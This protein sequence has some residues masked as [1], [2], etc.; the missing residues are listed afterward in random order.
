[1][2]SENSV[3][4]LSKNPGPCGVCIDGVQHTIVFEDRDGIGRALVTVEQAAHLLGGIGKPYFWKSGSGGNQE[5]ITL[6]APPE[7]PPVDPEPPISALVLTLE[8]YE[9]HRAGTSNREGLAALQEA[10]AAC[11]D[12]VLLMNIIAFEANASPTRT[13][14]M[15]ALN[16]RLDELQA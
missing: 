8:S 12:K 1:M 3:E 15:T 5:G 14:W 7:P 16:L 10:L 2:S 4:V 9:A 6:P 11:D 13:S